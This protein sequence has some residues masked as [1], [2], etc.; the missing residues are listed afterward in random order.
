MKINLYKLAA[1]FTASFF[2]SSCTTLPASV[3]PQNPQERSILTQAVG[4]GAATGAVVGGVIGNQAEENN[5]A[6][7]TA[8]GA[9]VGALVGSI[10]GGVVAHHQIENYRDIRLK[11]D[12]LE[13]LL[14]SARD[15]NQKIA[16]YNNDLKREIAWLRRETR[17]RKAQIA[18]TTLDKAR[19]EQQGIQNQITERYRLSQTLISSQ[20]KKYQK[21][22]WKLEEE[23]RKLDKSIRQL[24]SIQE[25][26]R[27]G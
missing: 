22:L 8:I 18:R 16:A 11:N 3:A 6:T 25:Q 23:E 4:A 12:E 24:R 21:T 1:V 26:V 20:K 10:I 15:Y 2:I 14:K 7:N 27:V 19:K 13:T 5:R 9:A 17:A